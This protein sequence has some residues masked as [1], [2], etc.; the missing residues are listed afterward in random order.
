MCF[1][2]TKC[3]PTGLKKQIWLNASHLRTAPFAQRRINSPVTVTFPGYRHRSPWLMD[4]PGDGK[5]LP[6]PT[7]MFRASTTITITDTDTD[8]DCNVLELDM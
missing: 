2:G 4:N 5:V 8:A 6:I 7:L 3:T 1:R